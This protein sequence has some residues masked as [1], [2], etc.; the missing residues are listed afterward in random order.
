MANV[1]APNSTLIKTDASG[2][3]VA[4]VAKT[5]Y[6]PATSGSA[7]LKGDGVGGFSAASAGTDYLAPNG[8]AAALTS[9]PTLNQDT[10]GKSAK[11]DALN[12]ATTV[13]N[14]ASATA[15]SAGQVLTATDSTH[16]TWQ[17]PT[18]AVSSVAGKTGAVTL[19]TADVTA[20]T[21]KQYVTDAELTTLANLTSGSTLS[22]VTT[23]GT[24]GSDSNIATEKAVRSA[25]SASVSGVSSVAGVAPVVSSGGSAPA[26][27]MAAATDSVDGYLTHADHAAFNGKQAALVSGTN[28]K[29][30]NSNSLVGSGDVVITPGGL[31]FGNVAVSGQTTVAS[32]STS[33]T[34]TLV[35]GANVTLTTDNSAKSVTIATSGGGGGGTTSFNLTASNSGSGD[36]SG[37][38]FNGGAAKTISYNT[39]GA[40]SSTVVPNTSP[41]A[42]QVLV[43]NAGGTAYAPVSLT[44]DVTVAST[45]VSTV[46]SKK[47]YHGIQQAGVPTYSSTTITLPTTGGAITYWNQGTKYTTASN[48]TLNTGALTNDTIYFIY[49]ADA[50]GTLTSSTTPWILSS[51]VPVCILFKSSLN[52]AVAVYDERHDYTRDIDWHTN[53]HA[54]IGSR[55]KPSDFASFTVGAGTA[56]TPANV[57]W[58]I[59]GGT[60]Y[61][62]D[63]QTTISSATHTSPGARCLRPL[64]SSVVSFIDQLQPYFWTSSNAYYVNSSYALTAL[65][66]AQF[67][68]VWVY[69]T[70]D[71]LKPFYFLSNAIAAPYTSA[72]NARAELPPSLAQLGI[73]PEIKLLYRIIVKGDT[74]CAYDS[75]QDDYRA[76]ASLPVGGVSASP[77]AS[78]VTYVPTSPDTTTNV[79]NALNNRVNYNTLGALAS[80]VLYNTTS[81]GALSISKVTLTQ[82]AT[83]S[84]VT[85]A[86]GKTFTC[87]DNTTTSNT[88]ILFANSGGITVGS[89]K[90]LTINNVLTL[91][92]TDSTTMTF[93][94]TSTNVVGTSNSSSTANSIARYDS[95]TGKL[96]KTTG[97]VIDDSNAV[98]GA[99]TQISTQIASYPLLLADAGKTIEMNVASGNTLTIPANASVA[100]PIGTVINIV[101]VGAGQTTVAITSD[102]L[103]SSGSKFKLSGQYSGATLYKRASTTW[104]LIGDISA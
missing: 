61:D 41:T 64:S 31:A 39:I 74:T 44:G 38:T 34:M 52:S 81:T 87:N 100:F 57:T 35:A 30:V 18:G 102:T 21:D 37:M 54:T 1:T 66:N 65:T 94:S 40:T 45:G 28:I 86:D 93:P 85:V 69:A 92:G 47:N 59:G 79:Q 84:T 26:I 96:I 73:T 14:V 42:G 103:V 91:A 77:S 68:V 75:T 63:L 72:A 4:A 15:P 9:F 70:A 3:P 32:G 6:A 83:G 49:F 53:A 16:A 55:I 60:L 23:L 17:S 8:S 20:S 11:T 2:A 71:T 95:T 12:S 89:S 101:Q 10:T 36:A 29:T 27:S 19:T 97:V 76:T 24:P 13:V 33:G 43:G 48:I 98:A 80:G 88:G 62:E 58:S 50:T 25:I 82:P 5:D 56:G 51:M 90:V 46:P 67:C 104:V 99:G 22:L 7:I 78:A